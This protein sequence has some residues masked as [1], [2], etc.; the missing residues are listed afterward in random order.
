MFVDSR[1]LLSQHAVAD[2]LDCQRRF[3]LRYRDGVVWPASTSSDPG[4]QEALA[5]KGTRFH[6]IAQQYVLGM[7]VA[8][9]RTMSPGSDLTL[10]FDNLIAYG[11][12]DFSLANHP[13]IAFFHPFE[14]FEMFAKFD[15]LTIG[16]DFI[17][18]VDWKTAKLRPSREYLL[19][20]P[21]TRIYLLMAAK[22]AARQP[23]P[24]SC[25]QVSLKYWFTQHP[26]LPVVIKYDNS[27]LQASERWLSG[28]CDEIRA[29]PETGPLPKT[30]DGKSCK[31][32]S[33]RSLCGIDVLPGN[34]DI[35]DDTELF[36]AADAILADAAFET[37]DIV[38]V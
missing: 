27:E 3:Q 35:I 31:Y 17:D 5:L 28:I 12:V 7:P 23:N 20:C 25:N 37:V 24:L 18:I 38:A 13:E 30:D 8:K 10:W 4:K 21:Q 2:Y 33:Y 19:A 26:Q 11:G 32:C 22:I 34:L 6:Q 16:S 15:M 36:F 29:L 9:L 14:G 1:F